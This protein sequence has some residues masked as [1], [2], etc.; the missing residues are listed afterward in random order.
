MKPTAYNFKR[1][2]KKYVLTPEQYAAVLKKAEPFIAEDAYFRS[3]IC[4]IYYDTD[5]WRLIRHSI[6][7][8]QFKAKLRL[9]SYG[10]P[11]ENDKIF[12]ELKK[13]YRGVVYKRRAQSTAAAVN[14]EALENAFCAEGQ[15]EKEILWFRNFYNAKPKA[16]I[17][18]DR[19][20]FVGIQDEGLRITFDDN[21]CCR[22]D[23]L[24]L[25]QGDDGEPLLKNGEVI[26]EVKTLG[27]CP[28]W[29]C[30]ILS[31]NRIMPASFSKYGTYYKTKIIT[32]GELFS[33]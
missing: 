14:D 12:I 18:Y 29:L 25:T 27:A 9:R 3:R 1:V 5:D 31:E 17:A 21:I 24:R 26:M 23:R 15:I 20:S 6:E 30:K 7:K 8:P 10:V 28:L 2:E 16:F 33:A 4:N 11:K 13:K 19:L 22:R 32:K